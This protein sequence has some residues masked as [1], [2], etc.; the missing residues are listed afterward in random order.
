MS[1]YCKWWRHKKGNCSGG[2]DSKHQNLLITNTGP[3]TGS[4]S[5][6]LGRGVS[7]QSNCQKQR[8][9]LILFP[10]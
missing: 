6:T 8:T 10:A 7:F 5:A 2:K 4:S 1:F 9:T 3:Y